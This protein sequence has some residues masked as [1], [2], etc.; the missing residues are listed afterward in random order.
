MFIAYPLPLLVFKGFPLAGGTPCGIACCPLSFGVI[1]VFSGGIGIFY[2]SHTQK[3]MKI[4]SCCH[5]CGKNGD[6]ATWRHGMHLFVAKNA[7]IGYL[8]VAKNDFRRNHYLPFFTH[9]EKIGF[10]K[11]ILY[12]N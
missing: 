12:K 2:F 5:K 4:W 7:E 10:K 3:K 1:L 11:A 9:T 8:F 6:M